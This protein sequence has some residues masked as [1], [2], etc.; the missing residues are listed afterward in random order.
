MTQAR[1]RLRESKPLHERAPR[2]KRIHVTSVSE[3]FEK[4]EK[5]KNESHLSGFRSSLDYIKGFPLPSEQLLLFRLYRQ[6]DTY[7]GP[8]TSPAE[9]SLCSLRGAQTM[10]NDTEM[11]GTTRLPAFA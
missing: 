3:E 7:K 11:Y 6:G 9:K 2:L 5:W 10:R 4:T 8:P 1:K